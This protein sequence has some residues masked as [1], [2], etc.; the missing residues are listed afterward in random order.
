[1]VAGVAWHLLSSTYFDFEQFERD[2]LA[3]RSPAHLLPRIGARL[4]ATIHQPDPDGAEPAALLDRLGARLYGQPMHWDLARRVVPLV[5][6]GDAVYAAGCDSGVPLALLCALRRRRVDF[7]ISFIDVT[8]HRSQLAGWLLAILRVRMLIIVPTE[9]QARAA[10]RSF[11]R[12]AVGIHTVDGQTDTSFFR[13]PDTRRENNP[14]LIAGSGVEQRDY[15]TVG[16]ALG[17][18]EVRVRVCFASPNRSDK[19]RYALPDPIPPNMEFEWLDFVELRDLYQQA[20]AVV[21]AL[22]PNR[23]SA[24]LTAM[25]EAIACEA[26]VVVTS[27]PGLIDRLI[28]EGLVIGIPPGDP[29]ALHAAVFGILADPE[30]ARARAIKARRVLLERYSAVAFLDDLDRTLGEM[31]PT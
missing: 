19:T 7:A 14:A 1:M 3:D 21:V 12:W 11:G 20:D 6:S 5:S 4:G 27:S 18:A 29:E 30:V 22:R 23:Y 8:R 10:A 25:L 28:G 31:A 9:L 13:P 16:Q 24:G 15:A 17:E 2:S 26:P